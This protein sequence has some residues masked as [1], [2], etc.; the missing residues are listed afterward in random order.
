MALITTRDPR[1][2]ERLTIQA[3]HES[4]SAL[5]TEIATE[6]GRL[7]PSTGVILETEEFTLEADSLPE[8]L[9]VLLEY[10]QAALEDGLVYKLWDMSASFVMPDNTHRL[11][12][13]THI[14]EA[15]MMANFDIIATKFYVTGSMVNS[16]DKAEIILRMPC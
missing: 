3:Q 6:V 16:L 11:Y 2:L 13:T 10:I 8:L 1:D 15:S 9:S 7:L 4:R 12:V 5:F 14:E